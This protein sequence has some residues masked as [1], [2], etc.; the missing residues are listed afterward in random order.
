MPIIQDRDQ[1]FFHRKKGKRI[2][3]DVVKCR[4]GVQ[5]V[6]LQYQMNI[7]IS[8]KR[9]TTTTTYSFFPSFFK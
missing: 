9:R 6:S 4:F 7:L 5:A 2:M 1:F 8:L 3:S